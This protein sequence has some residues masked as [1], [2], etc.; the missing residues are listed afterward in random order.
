MWAVP[1]AGRRALIDTLVVYLGALLVAAIAGSLIVLVTGSQEGPGVAGLVILSPVALLLVAVV[2]LHA[3]YGAYARRVLGPSPV[4]WADV[5][6]GVGMGIACFLGGRGLLVGL[7]A[8]LTSLGLEVPPVQESFRVI[9]EDRATAPALVLTA[10]LLAP[11]SEELLFRGV[12]FQGVRARTGF[13]GAALASAGMFTVAH[14]GD[15]GGPL[16][17][18]I[19]VAGILPLGV[20]FAAIM[21]WR[22]SLVACAVTHAVYNAGGVALLILT[23]GATPA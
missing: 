10:V 11:V 12:L 2:W 9:A 17:D 16:A 3:R 22:R 4:R 15:G 5:G 19:I 21:Q 7:V 6:V 13:W 23:S 20:V 18:L 8:L 14:V 1:W